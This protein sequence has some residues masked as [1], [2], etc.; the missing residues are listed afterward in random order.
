[1]SGKEG[2]F[3]TTRWSVV[4][5][6]GD[7]QSPNSKEALTTLCR[8]Y[9]YPVYAQF[10]QLG[11]GPDAAQDLTQGFFAE[12]LEKGSLKIADPDRGRFRSFL[13]ASL[14]HY[15]SHQ[16][17][18][19][20]AGKRGGGQALIALDADEA[21]SMYGLEPTVG[22]TP[23][24]VF[25]ERWART[26][27]QHVLDRLQGEMRGAG[28]RERFRRLRPFLAGQGE[29]GGYRAVAADL[30]ISESAVKVTLHRMRRRFGEILREEVAS[31]VADPED[32]DAEIRYLFQVLGA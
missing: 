30:G 1:M 15:L 31:T 20:R 11:T 3:D 28:G 14:R 12:L 32:I 24:S 4:A 26:L 19:E 8:V 25:E 6:A 16:R 7:T 23:E 13:K 27:L 10:R 21:E 22:E 2:D 5:A 29:R 17:R 18:R 9:W